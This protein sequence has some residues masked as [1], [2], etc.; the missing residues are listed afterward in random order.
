[1]ISIT[2]LLCDLPSY[3]DELRYRKGMT[4]ATRRPIVV[5]NCTRKCNLSCI[6]CYSNSENKDYEGE[7]TTG[8]AERMIEDLGEFQVPVL[9]FSGG[10]PLLRKDIFTLNI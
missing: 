4:P 7:L 2:R 9:L 8:Q 10:E 3:G 6:H 5:W 1:M